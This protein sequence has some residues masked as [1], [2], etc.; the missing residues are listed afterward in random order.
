MS[1]VIEKHPRIFYVWPGVSKSVQNE[2]K[3]KSIK[4][5]CSWATVVLGYIYNNNQNPYYCNLEFK[6]HASDILPWF[7]G[8]QLLNVSMQTS[9]R[10]FWVTSHDSLQQCIMDEYVLVFSL[11]LVIAMWQIKIM[12]KKYFFTLVKCIDWQSLSVKGCD[13]KETYHVVPL[14]SKTSNMSIDID[15][16][17]MLYPLQHGINHNKC[18]CSTNTST[19]K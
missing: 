6:L 15:S 5:S 11:N 13:W 19:A 8:H 14:C 9:S 3:K 4:S 17:F 10:N 12:Y 18:T 7:N 1:S 2:K 16:P